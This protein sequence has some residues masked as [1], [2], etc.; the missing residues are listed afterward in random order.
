MSNFKLFPGVN[1]ADSLSRTTGMGFENAIHKLNKAGLPSVSNGVGSFDAHAFRD[2][3]RSN[4]ASDADICSEVGR[5]TGS[6]FEST[7]IKM[8]MPKINY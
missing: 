2:V 6:S 3:A 4:F 5:I 7:L 1:L 8:S